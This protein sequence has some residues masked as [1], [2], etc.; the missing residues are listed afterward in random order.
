MLQKLKILTI[1]VKINAQ[2]DIALLMFV[3]CKLTGRLQLQ[4]SASQGT[5]RN[6]LVIQYEIA[7]EA[8]STRRVHRLFC[9]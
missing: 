4:F 7:T 3:S 5:I 1:N 8:Q 6:N 2:I 9:E